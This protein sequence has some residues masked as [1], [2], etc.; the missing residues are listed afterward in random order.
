M[1]HGADSFPSA[2]QGLSPIYTRPD[3]LLPVKIT[4]VH[5]VGSGILPRVSVVLVPRLLARIQSAR[6]SVGLRFQVKDR[7]DCR[8]SRAISYADHNGI[9]IGA[10]YVANIIEHVFGIGKR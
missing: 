9:L 1:A 5:P 4:M 8:R 6:V 2:A 3:E 10:H 7:I